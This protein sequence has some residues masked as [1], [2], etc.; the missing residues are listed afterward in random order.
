MFPGVIPDPADVHALLGNVR[1]LGDSASGA[2]DG[3]VGD[4]TFGGSDEI[5]DGGVFAEGY[6]VLF[7]DSILNQAER[8]RRS[9]FYKASDWP[10]C[11]DPSSF[12][13]LDYET[14]IRA[15]E[16]EHRP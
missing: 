15:V 5:S 10:V 6:S 8:I 4:V 16:R 7:Q 9:L 11:R 1:E 13:W 3:A 14:R 12:T 2:R